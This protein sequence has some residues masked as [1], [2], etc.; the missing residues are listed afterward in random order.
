MKV[1]A[2][3][4][5]DLDSD[6]IQYNLLAY[7]YL[8]VPEYKLLSYSEYL[9]FGENGILAHR[10]RRQLNYI[11]MIKDRIDQNPEGLSGVYKFCIRR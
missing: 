2:A 9:N 7:N 3:G 11:S 5:M 10:N 8:H 4:A 6:W 1:A